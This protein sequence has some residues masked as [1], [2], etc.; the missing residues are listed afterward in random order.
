MVERCSLFVVRKKESLIRNLEFG[1]LNLELYPLTYIG[2]LPQ[3]PPTF[4]S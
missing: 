2:A 1:I 3:T 4:L